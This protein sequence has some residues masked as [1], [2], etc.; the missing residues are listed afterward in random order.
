[1]V[2]PWSFVIFFIFIFRVDLH[3]DKIST[4]Q[5]R[6]DNT[7]LVDCSGR[8]N[9]VCGVCECNRRPDPE[10][11]I[12]GP[13]CECDNFSCERH[14]G[15]ICSGPDHGSCE[16][17]S[18]VCASGWSG[19]DCSCRSSNETCIK[20]RSNE[21]CSGHGECICGE[22]K[23]QTTNDG[24]YSGKFC[25]KCPTCPGRCEEF[26]DCVQCQMY[27]TGSLNEEEC[28]RNCT[29]FTPIPVEKIEVDEESDEHFCMFYDE[30]D[31]RFQFV[32]NDHDE[33]I[34]VKAQQELDCPPRIWMLGPILGMIAFIVLI[35]LAF[36]LLWKLLTTIH[37]RREFARFEKERML[38]KWDTVSQVYY[39][40]LS[41][42]KP[43]L[44]F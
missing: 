37:D 19:P 5:C 20:P 43:V 28:I 31:C 44:I 38:A 2:F 12:S 16:C 22:C 18:C 1:M 14:N 3:S 40:L 6:P 24:R 13:F 4:H 26:K 39:L 7:T 15:L 11:V 42:M 33:K 32:Y 17:G 21:I 36:L 10:E 25:E 35:G 29:L 23:C 27:K 34:V 41:N 9:C 8:G 30:N